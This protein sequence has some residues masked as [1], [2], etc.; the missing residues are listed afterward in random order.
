MA[1]A[2]GDYPLDRIRASLRFA[3]HAFDGNLYG[4][5]YEGIFIPA[6]ISRFAQSP[7]LAQMNPTMH[8]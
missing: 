3:F 1:V 5:I 6:P 2:S 7:I 4:L 8:S